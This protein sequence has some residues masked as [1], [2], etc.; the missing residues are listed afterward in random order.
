MR[1]IIDRFDPMPDDDFDWQSPTGPLGIRSE[2]PK[3]R[4]D[5]R[6][7]VKIIVVAAA[8]LALYWWL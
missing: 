8:G 4:S 6:L 3:A 1:N 7:A 5:W 2:E